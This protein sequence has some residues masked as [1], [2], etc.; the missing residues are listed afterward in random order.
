ML[1]T[2]QCIAITIAMTGFSGLL[3]ACNDGQDESAPT[4]EQPQTTEPVVITIGNLT[5]ITGVAANGVAGVNL[6][7]TDIAKYH[8]S[9]SLIP[10]IKFDILTYDGQYD[11]ARTISGYELLKEKGA[12][13]IFT[14]VAS[15]PLTLMSRLVEDEMVLCTVA[16]SEEA[17]TPPGYVFAPGETLSRYHSY[18]LLKWLAEEDPDFPSDRPARIGGALW[19]ESHGEAILR[20]AQEYAEAH[21]D[22]Y[23]WTGGYL[24]NFTF[25][26]SPEVEA[27]KDCDY[28]IPPVPLQN[29]VQ[30]YRDAGY[31]GKFIGTHSHMGMLGLIRDADVWDEIDGMIISRTSPWWNESSALTDLSKQLLYTYHQDEADEIILKSGGAYLATTSFFVLFELIADTV[32]MTGPDNFSSKELYDV[33]QSFSMTVDENLTHSFTETKRTSADYIGF[34]QVDADE[35]DLFKAGEEWYPIVTVP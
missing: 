15:V 16:P 11:P 26:W 35:E 20:G 34:Y 14:P 6:A 19:D 32:D 30:E 28:V 33:A 21:P 3:T 2:Y 9:E 29:F 12:D 27:L 17:I 4:I 25:T 8:N 23:D 13:L 22:Q 18:S 24:T 31:T 5:D 1:K 10:G 7:L